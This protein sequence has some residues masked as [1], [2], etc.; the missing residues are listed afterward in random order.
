MQ[1]VAIYKAEGS[2]ATRTTHDFCDKC[3]WYSKAEHV[4]SKTL[5]FDSG[6]TYLT[7]DTH[8]ID[9]THGKIYG[10]NSL[11]SNNQHYKVNLGQGLPDGR[12]YPIKVYDNGILLVEDVD[13][14][15]DYRA[16]S[17]T[18]DGGFTP[19]GA[20]TADYYKATTAEYILQP[21]PG[22]IMTIEHSELQL[23]VDC[24]MNRS[25]TFEVWVYHPDQITYPGVKI[26]Y[27]MI[28][29]NNIKDMLNACN[30]GTGKF[31]AMSGLVNDVVVLPFDYATSKPFRSSL[32]AEL[33]V[34][35]DG[36]DEISGEWATATFYITSGDE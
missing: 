2:S 26:P 30:R 13:Y 4:V 31:P 14:S 11:T 17:I 32:G 34:T 12:I 7:G 24:N 33:R 18:L 19:S 23:S 28:T 36:T 9:A 15:V 27:S 25:I 6:L 35:M 5:I 1:K 21:Y 8:L 20:L 22:K 16:G 10:E 3:T 29:Y